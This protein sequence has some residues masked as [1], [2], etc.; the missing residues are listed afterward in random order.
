MDEYVKEVFKSENI[1]SSTKILR[2]ILD[3]KY[4]KADK[5]IHERT[6]PESIGRPTE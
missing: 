1:H 4:E 3:A 5:K 6:I 2:K